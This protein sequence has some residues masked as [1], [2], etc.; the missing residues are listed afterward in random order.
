MIKSMFKY[1]I[2]I[3]FNYNMFFYKRTKKQTIH[4]L[5]SP[6]YL[7]Y[8]DHAIAEAEKKYLSIHFSEW[9]I[10]E[11][12]YTFYQYWSQKAI[13]RVKENDVILITG[14]GYAGDLWPENQKLLEDVIHSFPNNKVILAPQTVFYRENNKVER[15]MKFK[16]ILQNH[17]NLYVIA[18]EQNTFRLLEN[19]F[20]LKAH[21]RLFLLPDFV[22]TLQSSIENQKRQGVGY[23]LRDDEE[24]VIKKDEWDLLRKYVSLQMEGEH[25]IC[26]A[27]QHTEIPVWTRNL[28]LQRKFKEFSK[29]QLIIT[30]R[31]H[32]MI[33]AVITK[34]P[35][36]ALDNISHKISGVYQDIENLSYVRLASN[37]DEV[38]KYVDEVLQTSPEIRDTEL[39]LLQKN[40]RKQYSNIFNILVNE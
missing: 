16:K 32:G 11:I 21:D 14:G 4:I 24:K 9:N 12:N 23:C 30:D 35:C 1:I 40:I 39:S 10:D 15:Y 3:I 5:L 38:V 18:R 34:T 13:K 29:C 26:M 2:E 17:K 19:Q 31:L 28:F 33:F 27:K 25:Y 8:G 6:Q 22:L 37:I 7:N 20:E 36:I